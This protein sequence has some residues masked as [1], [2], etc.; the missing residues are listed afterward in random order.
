SISARGSAA[1]IERAFGV[2]LHDYSDGGA[3]FTA[4]AAP[5]RL[6]DEALDLVVGV[7]GLSGARRWQPHL[8]APTP[9]LSGSTTLKP[10]DLQALYGATGIANPGMGETVAIIGLGYAPDPDKDVN[11]FM[12]AFMPFGK[13]STSNYSQVFI[14][15]PTRDDMS[16]ANSAYVENCLDAEMVL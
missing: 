9:N 2:E 8:V 10:S 6:P 4:A 11:A 7:A 5:L 14:G 15:G 12:A 16:F 3:T 1:A 13:T